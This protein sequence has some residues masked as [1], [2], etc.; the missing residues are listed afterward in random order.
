M[1]LIIG[2]CELRKLWEELQEYKPDENGCILF[3]FERFKRVHDIAPDAELIDFK[4]EGKMVV[5]TSEEAKM[6]EAFR[7][8]WKAE[9]EKTNPQELKQ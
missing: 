9:K 6:L 3:N 1:K 4:D 2:V 8:V 5:I 7:M